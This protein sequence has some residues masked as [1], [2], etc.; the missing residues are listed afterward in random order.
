LT[1]NVLNKSKDATL[2]VLKLVG[3]GGEERAEQKVYDDDLVRT[4]SEE[5]SDRVRSFYVI[6]D[7]IRAFKGSLRRE[8]INEDEFSE[9]ALNKI[10]SREHVFR[11]DVARLTKIATVAGNSVFPFMNG[12]P[13]F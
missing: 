8:Q 13:A 11:E 5:F 2:S 1:T 12:G 4:L 10:I 9:I 3:R 7:A 6:G